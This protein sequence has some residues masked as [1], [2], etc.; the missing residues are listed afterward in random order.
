VDGLPLWL[1]LTSASHT[2]APPPRGCGWRQW[3]CSTRHDRPALWA[4]WRAWIIRKDGRPW[5][6]AVRRVPV[7]HQLA[8][9]IHRGIPPPTNPPPG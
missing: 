6:W 8:A 3:Q 9:E 1:A 2:G 7:H 5:R 4:A